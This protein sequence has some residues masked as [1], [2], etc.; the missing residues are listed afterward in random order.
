MSLPV[1]PPAGG[2]SDVYPTPSE[3][4]ASWPNEPPR[5][6]GVPKMR[7]TVRIEESGA[8]RW[9]ATVPPS[10]AL[11]R[12]RR[13]RQRIVPD[14]I[15]VGSERYLLA[16]PT[17]SHRAKH[18][19]LGQ[20]IEF[21]LLFG[22]QI[23]A[24]RGV[25]LVRFSLKPLHLGTHAVELR[26]LL[27]RRLLPGREATGCLHLL[28]N[29]LPSRGGVL[30]HAIQCRVGRRDL[31]ALGRSQAENLAQR[32]DRHPVIRWWR[33]AALT[34]AGRTARGGRRILSTQGS[35]SKQRQQKEGG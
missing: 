27:G 7:S 26:A 2:S 35:S 32:V 23:V 30:H 3:S 16:R 8:G 9:A 29:R 11:T 19:R 33:E 12:A 13:Q 34:G 25:P 20:R 6:S 5:N 31:R 4:Q 1:F 21:R 14:P 24:D 22:R 17:A 18:H 28:P 15:R 10:P